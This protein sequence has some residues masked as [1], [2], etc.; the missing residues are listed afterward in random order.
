MNVTGFSGFPYENTYIISEVIDPSLNHSFSFLDSQNCSVDQFSQ[1]YFFSLF[2][3]GHKFWHKIAL[4]VSMHKQIY[5]AS[6]LTIFE[7]ATILETNV[8]IN[9]NFLGQNMGPN[10]SKLGLNLVKAW[11]QTRV[12]PDQGMDQTCS[13]HGSRL[14]SL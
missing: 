12:K 1:G 9:K 2:K 4:H 13:K 3:S 8:I 6:A 10:W 11:V 7:D 14:F 5:F